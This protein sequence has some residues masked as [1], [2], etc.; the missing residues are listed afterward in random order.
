MRVCVGVRGVE[1]VGGGRSASCDL[2][3]R[4]N[5]FCVARRINTGEA[6]RWPLSPVKRR[7]RLTRW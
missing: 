2:A 5:P 3:T 6:R 4:P 1:V 7:K